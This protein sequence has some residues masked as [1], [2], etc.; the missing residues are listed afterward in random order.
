MGLR[1]GK[2]S[3]KDMD[4]LKE[5]D[6]MLDKEMDGSDMFKDMGQDNASNAN[7]ADPFG[8]KFSDE[9]APKNS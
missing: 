5:M 8:G 4:E 7:N 9:E 2:M 1:R 6:E 3:E